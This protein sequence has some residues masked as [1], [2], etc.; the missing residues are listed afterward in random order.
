MIARTALVALIFA[1]MVL[2]LSAHACAVGFNPETQGFALNPILKKLTV[3]SSK[4]EKPGD[5][6]LLHINDEIL[7]VN[8]QSV[9]GSRALAV[10]RYWKAIP[11][12][13]AIT[14][15]VRRDGS[16]VKITTR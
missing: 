14:F 13:S 16:V 1:S 10:M 4:L 9:P 2:P 6:C 11:D 12:G 8:S 3:S 5:A 7:Q 15:V